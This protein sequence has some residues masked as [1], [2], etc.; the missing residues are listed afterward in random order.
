MLPVLPGGGSAPATTA[1]AVLD[2]LYPM[3]A[4]ESSADLEH[5]TDAQLLEWVNAGLEK[6]ARRAAVFAERDASTSVLSGTATYSLPTR[7]L[8]S[9]HVSLGSSPLRPATPEELAALS[10]T[11]QADAR[12]PERYWQA[13]GLD[14]ATI[15]L[16]PLPIAS[17][18]LAVVHRQYPAAIAAGGDV[19][20]PDALG[21]YLWFYALGQARGAESDA[22]M[23]EVAAICD[24]VAS[25]YERVAR[26]M[27]GVSQ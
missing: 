4:A 27:W 2:E 26:E 6:L 5:W 8:S 19:P 3:L 25:L 1:Q 16:Y 14:T 7:H 24:Q 11:W 22:A 23:P 12:T 13:G 20:L 10:A 17:G 18:T 21:D 15:G 9:V